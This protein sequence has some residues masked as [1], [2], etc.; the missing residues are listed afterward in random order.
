MVAGF[1]HGSTLFGARHHGTSFWARTTN[2]QVRLQEVEEHTYFLKAATGTVGR[3]MSQGEYEGVKT[4]HRVILE[5]IP[6][7]VAWGTY[8][9]NTDTHFPSATSS[10]WLKICPTFNSSVRCSLSCIERA[11][12]SPNG[13]FGFSTMTSE[14]TFGKTRSGAILG[15]SLS[16][17]CLKHL[18]I[19]RGKCTERTKSSKRCFYHSTTRCSQDFSVH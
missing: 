11:Y 1:P 2:L 10:I 17:D 7:P 9:S 14:G 6:R 8:K 19:R 5:G 12:L 3:G 18:S 13:K 4:L 16:R 15:K